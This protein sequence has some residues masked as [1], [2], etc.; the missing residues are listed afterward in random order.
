[1]STAGFEVWEGKESVKVETIEAVKGAKS[2]DD[3]DEDDEDD[4]PEEVRKVEVTKSQLLSA[5]Q[6]ELDGSASEVLFEIQVL[7]GGKV[8]LKLWQE[9]KE[10]KTVSL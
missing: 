3:D 10:G 2:G 9:G 7:E 1:M 4:E 6:V 5:L 8:S